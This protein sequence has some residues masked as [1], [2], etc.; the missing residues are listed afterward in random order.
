[1]CK[2]AYWTATS[3]VFFSPLGRVFFS[4]LLRLCVRQRVS[5]S[6]RSRVAHHSSSGRDLRDS[7]SAAR[8]HADFAPMLSCRAV[9]F[10]RRR[11]RRVS[12]NCACVAAAAFAQVYS[13]SQKAAKAGSTK[14]AHEDTRM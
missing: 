12:N 2:S 13:T 4:Y 10:A 7:R 9:P 5:L 3:K 1:M 11:R 14:H 8:R 6:R